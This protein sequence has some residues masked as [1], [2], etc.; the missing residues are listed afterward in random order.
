MERSRE[1]VDMR[2]GSGPLWGGVALAQARVVTDLGPWPDAVREARRAFSRAVELEPHQP[3]YWLEWARFERTMGRIDEAV[4]LARRAVAEEPHAVRA[5]LLISRLELDR[6][7][8]DA[9]RSA[10]A[11]ARTSIATRTRHARNAYERDLLY[12]PPW[13]FRQLEEALQ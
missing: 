8:V 11:T 5:W 9:A 2:P 6:G 4:G 1:A 13:Q 12:A 7:Q 3:W 10:L